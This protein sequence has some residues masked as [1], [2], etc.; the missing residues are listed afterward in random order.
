MYQSSIHILAIAPYPEMHQLLEQVAKR[1]PHLH[2][3]IFTGDL[4]EGL[5]IVQANASQQ[6]DCILSRGGTAALIRQ[7]V[8][9]PVVEIPFSIYDIHQTMQLAEHY[10]RQYAIVGF[11]PITE[12]AHTLCDLLQRDLPILTIHHP[13]EIP[14]L[15]EQLQ[16]QGIHHILCDRV[17]HRLAQVSSIQ[18]FLIT[19][20]MESV[21]FAIEQAQQ[22]SRYLQQLRQENF[23]LKS[24]TAHERG[25]V[26]VL[27]P[28][29]EVFYNSTSSLSTEL[30]NTLCMHIQK[31]PAKQ[32]L[33]FYHTDHQK[34]YRITA[35]RL[36]MNDA[37]YFLFYCTFSQISLHH[38][39]HGVRISNQGEC[40]YLFQNSFYALR[41]AFGKM[42]PALQK[43]AASQSPLF[44]IGEPGTEKPHI[45]RWLYL[46]SVN[47]DKPFILVNCEEL[48]ASAWHSF[49]DDEASPLTFDQS[50]I[51][52]QN[53]EKLQPEQIQ[54]LLSLLQETAL[55]L[56]VR[57]LF[58][59]EA[60]EKDNPDIQHFMK[61]SNC[62][63][64]EIFPLRQRIDEL[65][66]LVEEWMQRFC[67]DEPHTRQ[68][69]DPRVLHQLQSFSWSENYTQL[70]RV[71]NTACTLADKKELRSP[72]IADAL[73][74]E[75]AIVARPHFEAEL[76]LDAWLQQAIQTA[77]QKYSGNRQK[78]AEI[79]G[80]SRTTLWRYMKRYEE[81]EGTPHD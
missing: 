81:Q 40:C 24:L 63:T 52:F 70:Q 78:V 21:Y 49:I 73:H 79:L 6:Y 32:T 29:G 30:H 47:T 33:K 68:Q 13:Q 56:R 2:I 28:T 80:I 8:D 43:L 64:Y 76:S 38:W 35:E 69:I 61:K 62:L 16:S 67:Q 74:Q 17:T 15:L 60:A 36:K 18:A 19:S 34:L 72:L 59:C 41:H 14:P 45:A 71:L 9:L 26:L 42:A 53:F 22:I 11:A 77:M 55:A 31:I 66:F 1:Y 48:S 4:E 75:T 5:S 58:S 44:L 57:L 50:T 39:T 12:V 51:Y 25:Q 37:T 54:Q 27:T 46:Q 10:T 23:F 20:S 65:P 3:D 7:Q